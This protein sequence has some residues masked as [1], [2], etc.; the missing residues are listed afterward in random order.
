MTATTHHVHDLHHPHDPTTWTATR[1]RGSVAS[2]DTRAADVVEAHLAR[3]D[4]LNPRIAAVTSRRDEE[5]R[6][7]A[8]A[9]DDAVA[10]GE[11]VG[12]LAGVPITVKETTDVAG[13]ATTHGLR[14]FA[15]RV[16]Q[17]DAPPVDLLRRAGA[18]VIGHTNMP[19]LTLTGMHPRSELFGD[20]VNPWDP[21]VT[22]GG[23]S[24]GD[25]AAVAA[26]LAA[27]G[28]GNDAGGSTRL[29]AQFCGIAGM[30]P[31]PG[32]FPADHRIGPDD[33]SPASALFP[34]DGPLARTVAD[35]RAVFEVLAVADPRDPRAVP[36]PLYGPEVPRT[37]G[38]VRDPGG[39]GVDQAV[40]TA[41]DDA[42]QALTDS[43][44]RV[45][46]TDVPMLDEALEVYTGMVLTEFA[47]NWPAISALVGP[48]ASRYI[49]F[50]LDE[51]PPLDLPGYLGRAARHLTVRRAW[52]R[53]AVD[54][55]LLL[56]PVSTRASFTPGQESS[57][58]E[59]KRRFGHSMTLNVW[60]TAVGAPA[61]AVPT[62]LADGR[63]VGVQLIG[64]AWREDVVLDAAQAVENTCG[65]L[66]PTE[67]R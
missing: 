44:Y 31:T 19:T 9:I 64:P 27:C 37:V 30:K 26:G 55:P 29:P 23:S 10:R 24:G 33:P 4:R 52:A 48:D 15:G 39:H 54:M 3:L 2:G 14:A 1:I 46:E 18:I 36:A 47:G 45:V 6:R 8:A 35:L 57:S 12:P 66:T 17:A 51:H 21:Q 28:L 13:L 60:S 5:A 7:D 65:V 32:R 25:A 42:A 41:L 53:H 16:A 11:E 20:T 58:A 63:P 34:V 40:L 38:I 49:N 62:G 61:V 67:P 22:P 50:D 59:E 56:G 43:G